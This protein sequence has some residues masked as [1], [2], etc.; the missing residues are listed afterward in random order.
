MLRALKR[1]RLTD[2]ISAA[3]AH[4]IGLWAALAGPMNDTSVLSDKTNERIA[5]IYNRYYEE[6]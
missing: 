2:G 5:A 3:E 4:D 6:D 1:L